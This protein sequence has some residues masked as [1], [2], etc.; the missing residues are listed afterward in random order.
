MGE[1][2]ARARVRV[3]TMLV[4]FRFYQFKIAPSLHPLSLTTFLSAFPRPGFE[5]AKAACALLYVN[6]PLNP[7]PCEWGSM[8][9]GAV[10]HSLPPFHSLH[11]C[12]AS[13][14]VG[15]V[16]KHTRGQD[17][18]VPQSALPFPNQDSHGK[19]AAARERQA[20]QQGAD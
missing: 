3:S 2:R 16:G 10:A 19:V 11:R 18:P 13:S 20:V 6:L 15:C 17:W 7:H 14:L 12:S 9:L 8:Q 5:P 4:L 1:V